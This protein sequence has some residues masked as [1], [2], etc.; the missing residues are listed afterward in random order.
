MLK[1]QGNKASCIWAAKAVLNEVPWF[2]H[3]VLWAVTNMLDE[4]R[5]CFTLSLPSCSTRRIGAV[6]CDATIHVTTG[7]GVQLAVSYSGSSCDCRVFQV[8][9]E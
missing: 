3:V 4:I 7:G 1:D 9:R 6:A 8:V 5:F 2:L